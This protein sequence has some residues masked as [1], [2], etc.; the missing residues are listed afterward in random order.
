MPE[1]WQFQE[2]LIIATHREG[3]CW[4]SALDHLK[5]FE[6]IPSFKY[7]QHSCC[8][9]VVNERQVLGA[10]LFRLTI[11][12]LLNGGKEICHSMSVQLKLIP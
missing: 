11:Y 1:A 4:K 2:P 5:V 3:H 6:I 7:K 9:T 10:F 8:H 12:K